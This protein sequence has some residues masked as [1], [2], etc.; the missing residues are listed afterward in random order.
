MSFQH[1]EN[2]GSLFK[3]DKRTSKTHPNVKGSALID[4][5]EYWI[6]GWTEET[7]NGDKYQSLK[8]E[9]KDQGY[10]PSQ[11][12]Q[13]YKEGAAQS[14]GGNAPAPEDDFNDDL[15]F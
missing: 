7:N 10:S 11:E 8:F 5:V 3:N 15:P 14:S 2:R 6:A 1:K 13:L 9:R 12:N 4:G